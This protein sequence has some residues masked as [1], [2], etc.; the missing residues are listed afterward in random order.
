MDVI[1]I[2]ICIGCFI[3]GF[4]LFWLISRNDLIKDIKDKKEK[5]E[6]MIL[7]AKNKSYI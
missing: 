6:K 7:I 5:S 4:G 3:G 2:S 1:L